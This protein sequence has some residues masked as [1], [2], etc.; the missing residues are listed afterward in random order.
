V[1]EPAE[2]L[3]EAVVAMIREIAASA[4]KTSSGS[5]HWTDLEAIASGLESNGAK[6]VHS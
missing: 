5:V 6:A 1:K 3:R 4:K 2:H